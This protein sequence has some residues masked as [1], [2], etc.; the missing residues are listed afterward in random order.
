MNQTNYQRAFLGTLGGK[1]RRENSFVKSC[2]TCRALFKEKTAP[3]ACATRRAVRFVGVLIII[4][5]SVC[6]V[7]LLRPHVGLTKRHVLPTFC[8]RQVHTRVTMNTH[9]CARVHA[10]TCTRV[11]SIAGVSCQRCLVA[12]MCAP[13]HVVRGGNS[14]FV[15]ELSFYCRQTWRFSSFESATSRQILVPD[16]AI[17]ARYGPYSRIHSPRGTR[18]HRKKLN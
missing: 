16:I 8:L 2:A 5:Y 13:A 6:Y 9:P 7:P 11:I 14:S 15:E 18:K 10:C 12:S 17:G 3:A 4:R 1:S